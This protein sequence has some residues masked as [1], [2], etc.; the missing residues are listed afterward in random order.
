MKNFISKI[1]IFFSQNRIFTYI[2][3]FIRQKINLLLKF[4]LQYPPYE[5]NLH[6]DLIST[7]DPIRYTTLALAINNIKKNKI[8]G[9]FAE[10]GVYRGSMSKIIHMC[11]PQRILYLFDTFEGFPIDF[12]NHKDNRFKDTTENILKNTIGDLKNIIIKKGIFPE[13]AK[14]LENKKF[15]FVMIDLD[16]YESTLLTLEFFYPRISLG[17]YI[18]IHD[19]NNPYESNRAVFKAV[20]KFFND[21][22]VLNHQPTKIK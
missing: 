22:T 3:R 19:Y 14:G 10:V 18:F 5:I 7:E 17:G 12:I 13:T 11:A 16:I 21:K 20:N 8:K 15:S 9:D 4:F 6:K 2:I 1:I